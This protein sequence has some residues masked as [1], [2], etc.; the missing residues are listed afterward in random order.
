MNSKISSHRRLAVA[1]LLMVL[2]A[3]AVLA[4]ANN[5]RVKGA[6]DQHDTGAVQGGTL[7][8]NGGGGKTN[9]VPSVGGKQIVDGNV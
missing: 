6:F 5:V 2:S 3:S 1:A 8:L 9:A 4:Q 7:L